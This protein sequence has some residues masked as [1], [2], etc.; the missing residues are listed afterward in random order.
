MFYKIVLDRTTCLDRTGNHFWAQGYCV[1][2][3]GLDE[4]MIRKYVK[5]QER[6]EQKQEELRRTPEFGPGAKL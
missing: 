1:G 6:Q 5:Y 3:V 4:D 2:T